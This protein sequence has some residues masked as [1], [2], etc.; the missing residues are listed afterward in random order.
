[1]SNKSFIKKRIFALFVSVVVL[2]GSVGMV[3]ADYNP[4]DNSVSVSYS[5][6]AGGYTNG[7][8]GYIADN[9]GSNTNEENSLWDINLDD[10]LTLTPEVD[11]DG[12]VT[13]PDD[14]I[15]LWDLD[16][17]M[18]KDL[19]GNYITHGFPLTYP[20]RAG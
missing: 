20:A 6:D 18:S 10:L 3:H 15:C 4:S 8:I 1:M 11:E 16:L 7:D 14:D 13:H 5:T 9:D 12:N 19:T 17:A 2:L